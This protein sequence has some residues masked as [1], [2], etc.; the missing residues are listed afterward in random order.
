MMTW[1]DLYKQH[2]G[3]RAG[4]NEA[5]S[6]IRRV[7]RSLDEHRNSVFRKGVH[8][9]WQPR[10]NSENN[11]KTYELGEA[12]VLQKLSEKDRKEVH[13]QEAHLSVLALLNQSKNHLHMLTVMIEG[14]RTDGSP[15][16]VA[17]HLPDDRE[18]DKNPRG[19]RQRYG[20]CGHASL[21]CH[22]GPTLDT[23]PE[24][25]VPL[26]A[27]A[28]ARVVEWVVSQLVPTIAFEPAPWATVVEELSRQKK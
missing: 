21:H 13:L 15:W 14:K 19:D 17:V 12:V 11:L 6:E 28:P 20:A 18:T 4:G 10:K 24:V 16:T 22:V 3:L 1:V 5:V 9:R 25:R 2:G 7:L 27:L 23:Q 26:P 8:Q